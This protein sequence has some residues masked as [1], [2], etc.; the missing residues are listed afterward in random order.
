MEGAIIPWVYMW[1]EN[2]F[3]IK[4]ILYRIDIFKKKYYHYMGMSTNQ[5][6]GD[7]RVC[8]LLT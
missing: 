1:R 8:S 7:A 5:V 2:E 4:L 3:G 6:L